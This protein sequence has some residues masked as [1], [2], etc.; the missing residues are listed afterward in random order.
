MYLFNVHDLLIYT[1]FLLH[2][3]FVFV[4]VFVFNF[5]FLIFF[6]LIKGLIKRKNFFFF[7]CVFF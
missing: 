1:L 6:L 2:F 3:V 4:F 5:R 7:K